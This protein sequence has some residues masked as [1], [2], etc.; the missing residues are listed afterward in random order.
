MAIGTAL[1]SNGLIVFLFPLLLFLANIYRG[2]R[3]EDDLKHRFGDEFI[4][5]KNNVYIIIPLVW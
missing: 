3:E 1:L 5:Y 4:K 2:R